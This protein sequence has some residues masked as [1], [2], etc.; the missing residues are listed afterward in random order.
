MR[1][2]WLS[3]L[4]TTFGVIG[5]LAWTPA[6]A[7]S[8]AD[9]YK[10]KT[11]TVYVGYSPGGGYDTYARTIAR[12]IGKQIPGEPKLIGDLLSPR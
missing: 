6:S 9:F 10:G 2:R 5:A 3:T 11:I 8:V 7:Q 1:K 4:I 12:H